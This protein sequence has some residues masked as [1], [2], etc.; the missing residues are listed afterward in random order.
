VSEYLVEVD[1]CEPVGLFLPHVPHTEE[2]PLC[3]LLGVQ[4][5]GQVKFI[6]PFAT[7]CNHSKE[8]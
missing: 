1:D 2:E 6:V 7:A 3:V 4:I 8:G 5:K